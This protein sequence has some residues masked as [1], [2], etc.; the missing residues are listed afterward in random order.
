MSKKLNKRQIILDEAAK[1]FKLKGFGGTSMRDLAGEVGM[2]AASMY[3]H[4]KSKDEILE[5]LCFHVSNTYIAQLAEVEQMAGSNGDK[6]KELLRRH[7]N[8]MLED[9]AAVSVANNDWKYLTDNKLEQ[10][11]AARKQYE[12][13]FAA[14]IE[15]GIAAGEF[16]PVNASVALFTILSA[17]RWVELWYRPG[18]GVTAQQLEED[19]MTILLNGLAKN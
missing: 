11:K 13:G 16:Q 10:F 6:L 1:L 18:R 15:N 7:I 14:L 17:V 19:I 2:E 12:K 4:I 3:N 9:G 5:H 8:L